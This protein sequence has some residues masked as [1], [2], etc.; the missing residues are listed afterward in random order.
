MYLRKQQMPFSG[1]ML[2]TVAYGWID[3]GLIHEPTL[4]HR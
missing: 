4:N 1:E 2:D 3:T